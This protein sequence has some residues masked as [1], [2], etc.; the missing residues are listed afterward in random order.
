VVN[1][2]NQNQRQQDCDQNP[3]RKKH[4]RFDHE[5]DSCLPTIF[6]L[7]RIPIKSRGSRLFR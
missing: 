5:R 6:N 3:A 1:Q 7:G 4:D 2:G